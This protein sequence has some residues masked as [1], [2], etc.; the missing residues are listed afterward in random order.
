MRMFRDTTCFIMALHISLMHYFCILYDLIY[1][2]I[3]RCQFVGG[4]TMRKIAILLEN[5]YDDKELI[6]P[7]YRLQEAGYKVDLV[8]TK[9]K[10]TYK[11]KHGLPMTSDIGSQEAN[12]NDYEALIIPGGFSPDYM[13]RHQATIDFAKA[14]NDMNKPIAAICHGPWLMISSC[15][16]KGRSLTGFHSIKTDIENAGASYQ[17]AQVVVDQNFITS[18]TPNDLP[19]FTKAIIHA[20]NETA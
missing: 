5:L 19:A 1:N 8:G 16:L 17:D 6:Y 14:M 10:E 3:K 20:L 4:V 15:D 12:P 2:N 9:K 7:Y 18:R 13:R 11:S